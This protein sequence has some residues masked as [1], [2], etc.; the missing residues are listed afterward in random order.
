MLS[1]QLVRQ[2]HPSMSTSED[3]EAHQ[4]NDVRIQARETGT[5]DFEMLS[6]LLFAD[7]PLFVYHKKIT[8]GSGLRPEKE[9]KDESDSYILGD[10]E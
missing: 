8:G 2:Q 7:L 4:R 6:L 1:P 9:V 10:V 5:P 3:A